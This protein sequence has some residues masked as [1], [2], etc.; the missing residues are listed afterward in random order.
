MKNANKEWRDKSQELEWRFNQ[1]D[2]TITDNA[3]GPAMGFEFQE[4]LGWRSQRFGTGEP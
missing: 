3:N 2:F 1:N 4:N